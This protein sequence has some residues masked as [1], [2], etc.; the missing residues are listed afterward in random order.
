MDQ[1]QNNARLYVGGIAWATTE[2]SLREAFAQFGT[3]VDVKI[4]TDKFSGRSKG[5]GFVTMSTDEE[6]A[7]A[8]AALDN[9]ELDG[10]TIRVNVARPMEKREER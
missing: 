2:D 7:A 6:A 4:I 3:V 10:R 9:Q 5:F 8:M 1:G